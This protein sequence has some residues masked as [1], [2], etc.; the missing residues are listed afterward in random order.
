MSK[1]TF[2]VTGATKG[3][4]RALSNRL[5][6]AGHH[7]VGLARR[8]DDP[9]FPGTLVSVDLGD[10]SATEES[11]AALTARFAFDGVVNNM[12]FVRL[13]RVGEIDLDDLEASFRINLTPAVQ[14]MQAILPNMRKQGWGRVVNLSSLTIL[15]VAQRSAY[16]AAKAAMV[17]MTR[18]WALELADAGITVNAIAPGPVETEMFRENTPVGSE[19]E[20][21]FLSL[22]PMKRLGKPDELAAGIEFLL[23]EDAGFITGQT[24]FI[25]G[26]GSIGKALL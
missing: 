23:S 26:G 6:A 9:T 13:A 14:T 7:V 19:A 10:R 8:T 22:I 21:R 12:G 11:L 24:L 25:D 2:L 15:G 18:T 1:R 16:A 4:G 17:T 5:A 3:I 20:Q